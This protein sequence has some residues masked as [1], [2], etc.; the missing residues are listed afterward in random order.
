MFFIG[1]T[2]WTQFGEQKYHIKENGVRLI[3]SN[4]TSPAVLLTTGSRQTRHN[5]EFPSSDYFIIWP[6]LIAIGRRTTSSPVSP[7][8]VGF[9]E[10]FNQFRRAYRPLSLGEHQHSLHS[11]SVNWCIF[12]WHYKKVLLFYFELEIN[13]DRKIKLGVCFWAA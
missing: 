1:T 10:N 9:R 12:H 2:W 6:W 5:N 8:C 3:T 4:P 13:L 7:S 11:A